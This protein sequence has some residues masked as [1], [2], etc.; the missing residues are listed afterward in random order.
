MILCVLCDFRGLS[1]TLKN[2]CIFQALWDQTSNGDFKWDIWKLK[3][4]AKG[5]IFRANTENPQINIKGKMYVHKISLDIVN[6]WTFT[7]LI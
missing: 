6:A 7:N 1:H 5:A 4:I 2:V 3:G